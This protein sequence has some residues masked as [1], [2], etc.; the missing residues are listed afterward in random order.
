[1]VA[2]D[3]GKQ[4]DVIYTDFSRAFDRVPHD[5]LLYKLAAYGVTGALLDWFKSYLES[6]SFLVVLN[7]YQSDSYTV[8]SGVPQGSPVAPILFNLFSNDLV[9]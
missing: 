2:I 3:N 8:T 5:I 1:M 4:V 7:G 6:R 9:N